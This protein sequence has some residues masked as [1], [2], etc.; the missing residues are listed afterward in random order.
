LLQKYKKFRFQEKP[1]EFYVPLAQFERKVQ[2]CSDIFERKMYRTKIKE[3]K[4]WKLSPDFAIGTPY[5]FF[6]NFSQD[7]QNFKKITFS[8][9]V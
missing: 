2:F 5:E 1:D 6:R 8:S 9:I 7:T 3:L 4:K